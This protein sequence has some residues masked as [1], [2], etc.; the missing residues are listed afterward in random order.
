MSLANHISLGEE[1]KRLHLSPT[2]FEAYLKLGG[3]RSELED[4]MYSEI[5]L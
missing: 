2:P 5:R 4:W 3:I 1:F